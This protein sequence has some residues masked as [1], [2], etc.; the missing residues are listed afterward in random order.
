MSFFIVHCFFSR[1][2]FL[3]AFPRVGQCFSW[4]A[5]DGDIPAVGPGWQALVGGCIEV[6]RA[7]KPQ[8]RKLIEQN[9]LCCSSQEIPPLKI[10]LLP[11]GQAG[12]VGKV[13]LC[14]NPLPRGL[15][16]A[17]VLLGV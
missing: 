7:P 15:N 16:H 1:H 10:V 9:I 12:F 3:I 4:T 13:G 8:E 5:V 11:L 14:D 17:L 6:I 2:A